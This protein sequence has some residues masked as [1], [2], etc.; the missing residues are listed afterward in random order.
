MENGEG[1]GDRWRRIC[2]LAISRSWLAFVL[3]LAASGASVIT[4]T[5]VLAAAPL[6]EEE[7][8]LN[9]SA[10]SA[11]LQAKI[12]PESALTIYKFDYGQGEAEGN[13]GENESVVVRAHLQDLLP[14]TVYHFQV[15]AKNADG[16]EALG[17]TQ[18]FTTQSAGGELTL[19]DG[20]VWELVSPAT[21]DGSD[22]P[23]IGEAGGLIQAAESGGAITY[24]SNGPLKSGQEESPSGNANETQ[25]LSVRHAGGGWSSQDIATPHEVSSG[26]SVG[27]GQEY[28]WFSPDL[29]LG[30]VQ[31]FGSGMT[32]NGAA[33]ATPLSEGASEKT[34]YLRSDEPLSP[35]SAEQVVYGEAE[36]E[37]ADSER[38]AAG[39][40][41]LVTGCPSGGTCRTPRVEE[42]ANV[43]LGTQFGGRIGFVGASADL[44][45]VIIESGLPLTAETPEGKPTE[46][47][48]LYEWAGGNLQ[49]ISVLPEEGGQATEAWFGNTGERNARGAVT[50]DGSR[51]IWS[52]MNHLF[53]RDV[54][55]EQTIELDALQG[56]S[57][58]GTLGAQFQFANNNGSKVFFTDEARLTEDSTAK[59]ER[60]DLYECEMV[61]VA[62]K[63]SCILSDLTVDR[64]GHADV[65]G[66]VLAGSDDGSHLYFVAKGAL[67]TE[68]E[69]N[70]QGEKAVIGQDNLYML[71]Y[72]NGKK[73]WE[74]PVFITFLSSE[75][76]HD[77]EGGEGDL[78]SVTARVSPNGDYLAFMSDRSLTGYNNADAQ[79]S[80]PDE[81]V[82]L[83][84]ALSGH[85]VCVSC[86]PTG[87]RPTGVLDSSEA[88]GGEGLLVDQQKL[89]SG[90]RWLAGN[91]PGWTAMSLERSRYQSRYLSDTGRVFFNSSDM[92]VPQATNGLMDV[93]EYQP[94]GVAGCNSSSPTFSELSGGCVGLISSGSSREES[95]FLDASAQGP[96]GEEAEDVFFLTSTPLVSEDKDTAFDVYDAHVCDP[97]AP[98]STKAVSPP[99][100]V[101]AEACKAAPSPQPSIFGASAS[102]TFSGPGNLTLVPPTAMCSKGKKL[103]HGKCVKVKKKKKKRAKAKRASHNRRGGR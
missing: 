47:A 9:I 18:S 92:L 77:W 66:L 11:T 89:W 4:P 12:N 13:A 61:E 60:P 67:T 29:S 95:V 58:G 17:G 48:G 36:R 96:G 16:E 20:R 90:G 64:S 74:P 2:G 57:G 86:N 27:K 41:P 81:E 39:Y 88:R 22:I 32:G 75:D 70:G 1:L 24:L 19:S 51:V 50:S 46:G 14:S 53:M 15:V 3:C 35:S 103:S 49:L 62:N 83:Y 40:L 8:V 6:I 44:T 76:N 43:P 30:L 101:T 23:P 94:D 52:Y 69:V 68:G 42:R 82:F 78:E 54:R 55:N 45:H 97:V 79:S 37:A 26:V 102:A 100:C 98:C 28:R 56:G 71:R 72:N 85:L 87:E 33:G 99:P 73:T 84:N 34:L 10:T 93:Y 38:G 91:V 5:S 80:Q 25:V 31:P 63:L 7:S 21:K 59:Y 65:E